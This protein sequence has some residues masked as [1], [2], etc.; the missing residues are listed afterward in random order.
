[1]AW[2]AHAASAVISMQGVSLG[3]R[4]LLQEQ[5]GQG[6]VG[7]VWRGFDSVL[8]RP[9]AVKVLNSEG[10]RPEG[11]ARMLAEARAIARLDHP[12]IVSVYDA[13]ESNGSPFIVMELVEGQNLHDRPPGDLREAVQVARQVC[14]ALEHAHAQGIVHRDLKPENVVIGRDG[15]ARLMDFGIARLV[16]SRVTQEGHI[17]GTV[18][19]LAPEQALGQ[20]F[21]GRADLYSLGVMLYELTTG[22]LPFTHD[23]PV[24]V[25]SQHLHAVPVPP[26][27]RNETIPPALNKLILALMS[28]DPAARPG[29]AAEVGRSLASPTLLD[30]QAAPGDEPTVLERIARGRLVGRE[31][32]IG[33]ARAL[34]MKAR[35]GEAQTLLIGGEPGVGKSRLLR[36]VLTQ[37]ELTGGRAL[38]A[39]C[40]AEAAVPY[41]G[42]RQILREV[43]REE[44]S[45]VPELPRVVTEDLVALLPELGRRFPEVTPR[46]PGDPHADQAR[47]FESFLILFSE[48]CRQEPLLIYLDDAHWADGGTLSL[49]RYLVRGSEGLRLMAAITYREQ[50]LDQSLSFNE[51]LLDFERGVRTT[52]VRLEPLRRNQT[53]E[54]LA[55]IFQE[56]ITEDFLEGIYRET[57]G[58]PFFTEEV[59]KALVESGKLYYREGRWHRPPMEELGIP[60]N[61]RVAIQSRISKLPGESQAV[62]KQAAVLGREFEVGSLLIAAE[63]S[64]ERMLTALEDAER[65]QLIE[66]S[67]TGG[68]SAWMFGHALIPST[69]VEGLRVVERRLLH[70]RAAGALERAHPEAFGRLARHHLEA[71][72][73]GKGIEYLLQAGNE[74]RLLHAHQEAI[75]CYLQ[76]INYY[77][78]AGN[79]RRASSVLFRL[80]LTYHN[81]FDF[82][83]SRKAYDRAFALLQRASVARDGT[84]VQPAPHPLRLAWNDPPTLDSTQSGD[85]HSDLVINQLFSGLLEERPDTGL[86]PDIAASWEVN[87][88]GTVYVFHLRPEARWSDGEPVTAQDF[89]FAWKRCLK[90]DGGSPLASSLYDIKGAKRYHQGEPTGEGQLGV[91]AP[92]PHKLVV[93]LDAPSS[94]FLSILA[95]PL[96][97][98]IPRHVLRAH[99]EAWTMPERIVTNGPYRL[100]SW[101]KGESMALERWSGYHGAFSGNAE[102]L[103]VKLY[104]GDASGLVAEYEGD[105]LD[106]LTL[107]E[108]P[109]EQHEL[110]RQRLAGEY[111]SI[112]VLLT[113]L[114]LF[115][116]ARPPFDDPRI[117]RAFVRAT[118]QEALADVATRGLLFPAT[119]SPVP[120]G[121]PGHFRVAVLPHDPGAARRLLS[122]AGFPGGEGF[123]PLSMLVPTYFMGVTHARAL[124]RQ[125]QETLG[126]HVAVEEMEVRA[127][128]RSIVEVPHPL[129]FS[130]WWADYPDPYSFLDLRSMTWSLGNSWRDE[131][132]DR[133]VRSGRATAELDKRLEYYREA[134]SVLAEEVPLFPVLYGRMHFLL[135]PWI[136]SFPT[137]PM[138]YWFFKDVVIDPH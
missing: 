79:D 136:A 33:Q 30:E 138:R 54:L 44:G 9:V 129:T 73:L 29:S 77:L 107:S 91:H 42:F 93:E 120:P 86:V 16:A 50:E 81:A 22:E 40:Y 115:D 62:L 17:V 76:A 117:R 7:T 85:T 94:Y 49:L 57:E 32:E 34:W 12:N 48:F 126:V 66:R 105:R 118:D 31:Q 108:L 116:H 78:E 69:L 24:A 114:V 119:G 5:I 96:T 35:A 90:P 101:T 26:R 58:N 103:E 36:E 111:V 59:C 110:S 75:R 47:L 121:I 37:V 55:A 14:A 2:P 21:D 82:E 8:E 51:V 123:P 97:F 6:G 127:F 83:Q 61:V 15:I 67:G 133:L 92:D 19:Y 113:W 122:D 27:A 10:L 45:G 98:P 46:P 52:S 56:E 137:S 53:G 23:D 68:G 63:L 11:R 128:L 125:W 43:F 102:R 39:A 1:M 88:G 104:S 106:I 80:A 131:R 18:F 72:E 130:P 65:A 100:R 87:D 74:A 99:G 64:E 4:Y 134:Q 60:K 135:K 20:E 25:I 71:G 109:L 95:S 28:K 70:H 84:A 41:A 13:G 124:V 112:P 89:A 132:Y 3:G 38:G